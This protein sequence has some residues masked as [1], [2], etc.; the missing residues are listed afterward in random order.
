MDQKRE[1]K[2]AQR[3]QHIHKTHKK[4]KKTTGSKPVRILWR[5]FWIGVIAFNLVI[6]MINL[7]LLGYMPSMKELENP[8][9]ALSSEVYA[10]DQTT[11]L[12]RYFIQDR[13]N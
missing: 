9:S 7:G 13:S 6:I 12:G 1:H 8:S 2:E 5:T 4:G 11:L 3:L 10:G